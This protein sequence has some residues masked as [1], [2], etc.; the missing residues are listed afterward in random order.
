MPLCCLN[1]HVRQ[2]K[3]RFSRQPELHG[4]FIIERVLFLFK[5]IN[6][7]HFLVNLKRHLTSHETAI[8]CCAF[9]LSIS[10][11]AF[12]NRLNLAVELSRSCH[13]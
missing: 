7:N 8:W 4:K 2:K 9:L 12:Y 13:S 11:C 6:F 1:F 5:S 10:Q 3:K